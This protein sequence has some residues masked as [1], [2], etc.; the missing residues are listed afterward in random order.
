MTALELAACVS[1]EPY[2]AH[3]RAIVDVFLQ[4][5]VADQSRLRVDEVLATLR[6]NGWT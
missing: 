6:E 5:A 3:H 2:H 1:E 4:A